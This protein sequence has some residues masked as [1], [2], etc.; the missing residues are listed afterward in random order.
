MGEGQCHQVVG[1]AVVIWMLRE[2]TEFRID[3][4]AR[5]GHI[6][7]DG[8]YRD[9]AA[10]T[11]GPQTCKNGTI[12]DLPCDGVSNDRSRAKCHDGEPSL[13][14]FSLNHALQS[15]SPTRSTPLG[16]AFQHAYAVWDAGT[17][18]IE[19]LEANDHQWPHSW[20]ESLSRQ[21]S[22]E[23]VRHLRGRSD[24][25]GGMIYGDL[26]DRVAVDGT[27]MH[28]R[29]LHSTGRG[30]PCSSTCADGTE[31]PVVWEGAE[32]NA[33]IWGYLNVAMI[34]VSCC[35]PESPQISTQLWDALIWKSLALG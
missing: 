32:P 33:M 24:G 28:K 4:P 13:A 26:R 27:Q 20:E 29:L 6:E 17:L 30:A 8:K 9:G 14:C 10:I 19:Y 12:V 5:S 31:F 35:S 21:P 23:M 34:D 7:G 22:R 16:G 1:V 3:P 2:W 11:G 18:V 25:K 15:G